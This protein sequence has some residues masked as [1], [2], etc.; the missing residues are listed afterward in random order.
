MEII[1]SHTH[2]GPSENLGTEVTTAEIL[3]QAERSGVGRIVVFP[4]P[5]TALTDEGINEELLRE[6]SRVGK[7]VPYYYIPETLRPIPQGKGYY[8]G[9]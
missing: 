1:D 6:A 2:W 4:F 8:G 7:L 9:K 3:R 5:S